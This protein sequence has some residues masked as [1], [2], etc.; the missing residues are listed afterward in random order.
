MLRPVTQAPKSADASNRK[1]RMLLVDDDASLRHALL[2]MLTDMFDV[3]AV[4]DASTALA[5]VEA[6]VG[7]ILT[8]YDMAR[9]NRV[10]GRTQV[11]DQDPSVYR[12]LTSSGHVPELDGLMST[13][14]VQRFLAKPI[15]REELATLQRVR[16][17]DE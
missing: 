4:P 3:T 17:G 14:L 6:G 13:G 5:V 12:A 9:V 16:R 10:V 8:A 1:P 15:A 7:V 2:R 11:R